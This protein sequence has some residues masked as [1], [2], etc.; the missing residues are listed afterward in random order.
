MKRVAAALASLLT[1][2]VVGALAVGFAA[3]RGAA[4][5]AV[6]LVPAIA[7][8]ATGHFANADDAATVIRGK[9]LYARRCAACHGRFLQGQPLWQLIDE[10][11][12]RRAPAHDQ[13]GHTWQH[14]DEELFRV[15][16]YGSDGAAAERSSM[17]A[18]AAQLSDADILAVLAFIKRSW[19]IGLRVAQASLNPGGAG[20]PA[21]AADLDWRLPPTTCRG[22]PR[23]RLT[24]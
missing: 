17:P 10:F 18:F 15:T 14:S 2:A 19:P 20:T 11:A 23:E 13:T 21:H 16:K 24:P 5:P 6:R 9:Q 8:P 1:F 22:S 4:S 3:R 7:A 12:G